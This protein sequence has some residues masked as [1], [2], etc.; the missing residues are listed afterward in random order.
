[1]EAACSPERSG[2]SA[3]A[4]N[5]RSQVFAADGAVA[6][7]GEDRSLQAGSNKQREEAPSGVFSVALEHPKPP[8][9]IFS[10]ADRCQ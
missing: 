10:P 2:T 9:G 4:I 3:G 1:M 5:E 7:I 6:V 8:L